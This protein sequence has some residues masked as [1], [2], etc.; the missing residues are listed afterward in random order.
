MHPLAVNC[1]S[2]GASVRRPEGSDHT[3]C[4]Y[5]RAT[6]DLGRRNPPRPS[7]AAPP[8]R[9][10]SAVNVVV[11]IALFVLLGGGIATFVLLPGQ[12]ERRTDTPNPAIAT[13]APTPMPITPPPV[14]TPPSAAADPSPATAPD[15]GLT[16]GAAGV[17]PAATDPVP[18]APPVETPPPRSDYQ[19]LQGCFARTRLPGAERGVGLATVQLALRVAGAGTTI[20]SVGTV[21]R[22]TMDYVLDLPGGETW[23]LPVTAETAPA[24]EVATTRFAIAMAAEG[25]VLV[26][27]SQN[28]VTGWS[29]TERRI[30]WSVP[31]GGLL[32]PDGPAAANLSMDCQRLTVQRG[33]VSIPREGMRPLKVQ[34]VDG[35]VR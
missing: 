21:R 7:G 18:E 31:L 25:D 9:T 35:L 8:A 19:T 2:C 6:I 20:T 13:P 27:A 22:F 23:R 3:S 29:L 10:G 4:P 30:R 34:V 5:C 28:L 1:P 32:P 16:G 26:V 17:L 24:A 33:V 12:P 14:V 11:T 15:S